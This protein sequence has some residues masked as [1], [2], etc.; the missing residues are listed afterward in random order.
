MPLQENTVEG[1]S[2]VITELTTK[3]QSLLQNLELLR[4]EK[5]E[6]ALAAS[7]GDEDARKQSQRLSADIARAS[8]Q[9]DELNQALL[10]ANE[11]KQKAEAK[12][13]V[14]KERQRQHDL[15]QAIRDYAEHV[16]EL[17]AAMSHLAECFKAAKLALDLAESFMTA[18]AR[19]PTQQLRSLQGATL[20]ASHAGLGDFLELSVQTKC[21]H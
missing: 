17:D 9:Y 7:L 5:H 1:W 11:E 20:A 6:L 4:R 12:A 3:R 21:A 19:V 14:E 15:T 8:L 2:G 13:A 16:K 10:S 18:E